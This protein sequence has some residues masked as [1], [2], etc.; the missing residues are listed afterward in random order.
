ME[1]WITVS[2]FEVVVNVESVGPHLIGS[3]WKRGYTFD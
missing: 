3:M 1:A 2:E